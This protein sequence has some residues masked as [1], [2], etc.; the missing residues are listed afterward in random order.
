LTFFAI[1]KSHPNLSFYEHFHIQRVPGA[2][3]FIF[4]TFYH[5]T[6]IV[7]FY[8]FKE[9]RTKIPHRKYDEKGP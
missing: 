4:L 8:F 9:Q 1:L 5:L 3:F 6:F 2:P 7:K